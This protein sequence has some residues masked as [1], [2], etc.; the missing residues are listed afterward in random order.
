M[1]DQRHP[2]ERL[3][4][5]HQ[6]ALGDFILTLPVLEGLHLL[7]PDVLFDF[8]S[9]PEY[10]VL[11]ANKSYFGNAYSADG[12]VP[13]SLYHE[14]LWRTS[15]LAPYFENARRILLFGQDSSRIIADRLSQLVSCPVHWI[16]SFPPSGLTRPVTLFLIDQLQRVGLNVE[17]VTPRL[18]PLSSE[19]KAVRSWITEQG[20]S[21]RPAPIIIHTGS[22]G[23]GKIWPLSRWWSLLDWLCS[24]YDHPII[25]ILGQADSYLKPFAIEAEQKLGVS[26]LENITLQRLAALASECQL[27]VGNDS[28]VSHLA[29]VVGIPAVVIFGP[30]LPEIWAPRGAKVHVVRSQW[31]EPENLLWP[32]DAA[33]Q[34]VEKNVRVVIE[35][36][37]N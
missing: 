22:G 1:A 35:G 21:Q 24:A 23:R 34:P 15:K 7:W 30:T 19:K 8:C 29:G 20:W 25:I 16:R 31:Q 13:S 4:I 3:L 26:V 33:M 14:E 28:G 36:L 27:Y 32:P 6:G 10:T 17:Y 2:R 18:R 5:I 11:L 9:R 37:L 12:S